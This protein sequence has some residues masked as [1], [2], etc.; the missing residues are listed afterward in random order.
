MNY[1]TCCRS[2]AVGY[3]CIMAGCTSHSMSRNETAPKNA[4]SWVEAL[5]AEI[6]NAAPEQAYEQ[7]D[8]KAYWWYDLVEILNRRFWRG[9]VGPDREKFLT[10][11]VREFGRHGARFD[12][13]LCLMEVDVMLAQHYIEPAS[14]VNLES[15]PELENA[16]ERVRTAQLLVARAQVE[17]FL[18]RPDLLKRYYECLVWSH[19]FFGNSQY[20]WVALR[21]KFGGLCENF[22][23]P[24]DRDYWWFAR[25]FLLL[26]HA[27]GRNELLKGAKAD[28][29]SRPFAQFRQWFGENLKHLEPHAERPVWI[30]SED[31]LH[32]RIVTP[33]EAMAIREPKLPFPD[34]TGVAPPHPT[35]ME[36]F[37]HLASFEFVFAEQYKAA[38]ESAERKEGKEK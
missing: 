8:E 22:S 29:L 2:V 9:A 7:Y 3:F 14:G 16:A 36:D 37:E 30:S 18:E 35:L 25:D 28:E 27:T 10:F 20:H 31:V 4:H 34:W 11:L 26:V 1:K 21:G 17:L 19:Q 33:L 6:K 15:E 23:E 5:R 12:F 32:G 38:K 24:T 13:R